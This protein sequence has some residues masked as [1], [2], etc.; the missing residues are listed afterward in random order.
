MMNQYFE[1]LSNILTLNCHV[2]G[3][4]CQFIETIDYKL[5][6]GHTGF[7]NPLPCSEQFK[8]NMD[9]DCI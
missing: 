5:S 2:S 6:D 8:I 7:P 1:I 3:V 9:L 4:A